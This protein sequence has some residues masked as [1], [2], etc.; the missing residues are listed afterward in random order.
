MDK[1]VMKA[2]QMASTDELMDEICNRHPNCIIGYAIERHGVLEN[3]YTKYRAKR[4]FIVAIGI[5]DAIKDIIFQDA[6]DI[7][8]DYEDE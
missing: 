2:I 1:D 3:I 5:C 7:R 4:G 8:E 6:T